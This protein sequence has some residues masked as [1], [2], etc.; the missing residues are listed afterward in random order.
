MAAFRISGRPSDCNRRLKVELLTGREAGMD[1]TREEDIRGK[2]HLRCFGD[3]ASEAGLMWRRTRDSEYIRLKQA[4]RRPAGRAKGRWKDSI[5]AKPVGVR[6][7]H[8]EGEME[9]AD[10]PRPPPDR[11]Q[12]QKEKP[13][14]PGNR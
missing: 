11:E 12:L 3:K 1:R 14:L 2:E 9:A 6:E 7:R 13:G 4:G 10:W 5:E 8:P